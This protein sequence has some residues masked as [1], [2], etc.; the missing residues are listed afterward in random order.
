MEPIMV[1]GE[2]IEK[3]LQTLAA[4]SKWHSRQGHIRWL[5]HTADRGRRAQ[6]RLTH[7]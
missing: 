3:L 5:E 2:K 6:G 1:R 4:I 7:P